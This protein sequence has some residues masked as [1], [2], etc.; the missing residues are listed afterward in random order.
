MCG[1]PSKG[2]L[3]WWSGYSLAGEDCGYSLGVDHREEKDESEVKNHGV[4]G[5]HRIA[6]EAERSNAEGH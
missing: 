2:L 5:I 6:V 3:A 4:E 1:E